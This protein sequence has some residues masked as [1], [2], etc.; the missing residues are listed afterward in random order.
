MAYRLAIATAL[1]LLSIPPAALPAAAPGLP[2]RDGRPVAA[3]VNDEPVYL[4]ELV[5]ELDPPVDRS[6]LLQGRGTT[7]ELELLDRLITIR[8][9]VQEAAT[10]GLADLPEIRKQVDV[11]SRT[12][13]R[14]VLRESLVKDLEPDAAAVEARFK[15]LVREY[16][17]ASLLFA[18]EEAARQA[19]AEI[20]GGKPY[21][22]VAARVLAQKTATA[23]DDATYHQRKEYLP[24]VAEAIAR[25]DVGQV[26]PVLRV[27]A[28]FVVVKVDDVRY[29]ESAEARAEARLQV[30]GE[31]RV[32]AL[33]AH[34]EDLRK[35]YVVVN[36]ALLE[37][38]DYEAK[39]P[40]IDALLKDTRVLAEIKGA[41]PV[42]IGDLTDDLRMQ[43]FHRGDQAGQGRR[44]NARKETGLETIVGRR[45]MNM[46][47]HRL[48]MDK[49]DAY[50]DR[51][52]AFESSLVFET[53]VQKVIVPDS[54]VGEE[55]AKRYYADHRGEYSSPEMMKVRGLAFARRGAAEDAIRKLREGADFGW[56]ATLAEGQ[57]DKATPGVLAFD[58]KPITT[59][60]MPEE[61]Q[62]AVAGSKAG[63]FRLYE[64]PE[65]HFYVLAIQD[66]IAPD[67]KPYAEARGAIAKKLF[68]EKLKRGVEEY[69]GKLRALSTVEVYLAKVE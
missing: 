23:K 49:T 7:P 20:A 34:E 50:L 1:I 22:E 17:T 46:E 33:R 62:E 55:E 64:S 11:E 9:L 68:G 58:G 6:R 53:F 21:A 3:I 35:Q 51:V 25:L 45:L 31:Q 39:E 13:L 47:A 18:N 44:L 36:E 48:G 65:G 54:K 52:R 4:D 32:A 16:K 40:G 10:M 5:A 42:T 12:I 38:L 66:V 2:A 43:V 41:S 27:E 59:A 63:E 61:M 15:D 37:S 56:L 57:V 29:P 30:A 19:H 14:D 28:G 69:A 26:S 67:A 8:L 24:Q 60:S